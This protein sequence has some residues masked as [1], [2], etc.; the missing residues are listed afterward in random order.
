MDTDGDGQTDIYGIAFPAGSNAY[1]SHILT[2]A[3]HQHGQSVFDEGLNPQVNTDK[4]IEALQL[5]G[6]LSQYA[7][8]GIGSYSYYDVIDAF[9]AEKVAITPYPGRL[10]SHVQANNPDLLEV[11]LGIPLVLGNENNVTFGG[12]DSYCVYEAAGHND[13]AKDFAFYLTTGEPAGKFLVTVPGHLLPPLMSMIDS[14]VLWEN[15]LFISHE[16]DMR[17]IFK[18]AETGINIGNEA[19]AIGEDGQL[20]ETRVLNPIAV[21]VLA[22]QTLATA[23]QMVVLEGKSPEEAAAFAQAELEEIAAE[24]GVEV[25]AQPTKVAVTEPVTI[26]FMTAETDPPSVAAYEEIIASF[27]AENPNVTISLEL[28]NPDDLNTKLPASLAVGEPPHI[29]QCDQYVVPEFVAEGHLVPVDDAID[30]AGGPE[31]FYP[32]SLLDIDG[33]VYN[34]PYAGFGTIWWIRK[35]LFEEHGVKIPETKE[36]LLEAAEKLTMDTDGDGQTDIYGIAFP[37]GSNAYTSHIL[38]TAIHQHGQSVFDADL[39]PQVNTDKAIAALQLL[40]DLSEFAPP[41]IGSY[42]YYDVI[43]AF[44]AEKVAITPY[45]GRLLSHVQANNPDLLDVTVGIPLVLGNENNVTFGGWDSYCVYE[46]AGHNDIAKQFAFYLTTG[47][48][49]G[50]F[51]VTVPGHLLPPLMSMIDSPVLWENELFISHEDD[52]RTIFK[53]AETGINIGNE[54]GAIGEDG[55]LSDTRVLNPNAVTLL[56][57]Q[58]FAIAVQMVVLEGK[59][60]EEAAAW[61]QEELELIIAEAA[62]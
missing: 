28:I 33:H 40:G 39:N 57:R 49:A 56:A 19:G 45:P 30:A 31:A 60:P 15:E 12:W 55:Q 2:T 34:V 59:S 38:T 26:R 35:D 3:I 7:P 52:M 43:D 50:K 27:E 13:I 58:T 9:A 20:T 29:A 11:T 6:D 46:A 5:L 44:A 1:T 37:A 18:A 54:A 24:A 53:A 14:P 23:S 8:P 32:G 61:A 25:V 17:T 21:T 16:E 51:L 48:P 36:E 42:S 41:G 22:R 4:A 10:L 62:Q 47:E